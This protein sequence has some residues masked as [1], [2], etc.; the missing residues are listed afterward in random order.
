MDQ[1][2]T[3]LY[4]LGPI[5]NKRFKL[6]GSTITLR[7]SA[8]IVNGGI[9][10]VRSHGPD[11]LYPEIGQDLRELLPVATQETLRL[12][13]AVIPTTAAATADFDEVD[14]GIHEM[15][16]N[17]NDIT[18]ASG[19][20]LD[21]TTTNNSGADDG[22]GFLAANTVGNVSLTPYS[23]EEINDM[24]QKAFQSMNKAIILLSQWKAS[25]DAN[26]TTTTQ[27]ETSSAVDLSD[28]MASAAAMVTAGGSG[29]G[30]T[31][32]DNLVSLLLEAD[33]HNHDEDRVDDEQQ[34]AAAMA[35][36]VQQ[37]VDRFERELQQQRQRE[38][39]HLEG[40]INHL[41]V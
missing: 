14:G 29:H 18:S 13:N 16:N 38:Q 28:A 30:T 19:G 35:E 3:L 34:L 10:G 15:N 21:A 33:R 24:Y 20:I 39:Q 37:Q 27:H 22:S 17:I 8:V 6:G 9:D 26:V 36:H 2:P 12:L 41:D 1:Q 23:H 7:N 11:Y 25:W 4:A 32:S 31:N 40:P 5:P